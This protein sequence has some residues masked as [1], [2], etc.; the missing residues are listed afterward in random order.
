MQ[1]YD[2]LHGTNRDRRYAIANAMAFAMGVKADQAV[3]RA[4]DS[5][6]KALPGR[7]FADPKA[8]AMHQ[9]ATERARIDDLLA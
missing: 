8:V 1:V 5:L 3:I 9:R 2:E 4:F 6:H 7:L